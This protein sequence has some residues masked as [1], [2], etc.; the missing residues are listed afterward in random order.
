MTGLLPEDRPAL[1]LRCDA[2]ADHGLGHLSRC[3]AIADAARQDGVATLFV[4]E[5]PATLQDLVCGRG[6]AVTATG[7]AA[8]GT[9]EATAFAG[10]VTA[11]VGD[12]PV[13]VLIDGKYVDAAYIEACRAARP[14]DRVAALDDEGL[15]D[16]PVDVLVNPHPFVGTGDY[17]ARPGRALLLGPRY[18]TVRGAYFDAAGVADRRGVLITLGGEDPENHA[19]WLLEALADLLADHP[20]EVVQGPAHPD[21]AALHAAIAAHAPHATLTIAPPD[22]EAPM[23]RARVALSA[24]GTTCYELMA[25]GIATAVVAVEPH[26][27][28][29]IGALRQLGTIID[30]GGPTLDRDATHARVQSLLSDD[31]L[32]SDLIAAG[33]NLFPRPGTPEITRTLVHGLP[34]ER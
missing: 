9:D 23:R 6:H 13:A 16:L 8:R 22:L 32:T 26:Q 2:G 10:A 28:V 27:R 19:A 1:A 12:R 18:N 3:L 21:P 14:G 24:G 4:M 34:V 5:A 20:V 7:A 31:T 29:L 15:R 17:A 25:A 30:L 33:R 11:A